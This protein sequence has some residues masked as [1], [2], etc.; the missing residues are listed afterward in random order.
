M[1]SELKA[2]FPHYYCGSGIGFGKKAQDL[3]LRFL[4]IKSPQTVRSRHILPYT[5][6][7][8]S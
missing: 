8:L 3:F 6:S 1:C 4:K 5:I 7:V 2:A